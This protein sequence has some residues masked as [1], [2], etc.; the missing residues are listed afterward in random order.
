MIGELILSFFSAPIGSD[1]SCDDS[2]PPNQE[3]T[4]LREC[5]PNF[6]ARTTS[7]RIL[8]MGCGEGYQCIALSELGAKE[9]IGVDPNPRCYEAACQLLECRSNHKVSFCRE[10]PQGLFDIIL[11]KDAMEHYPDP[12]GILD[13]MKSMLAPGGEIL[14]IFGPP[15]FAPY[16]AHVMCF[17]KLPWVNIFFSEKTVMNVRSKYRH[18]GAKRY[19]EM[20][21]GLNRMTIA[22]FE[23]IIKQSDLKVD[24]LYYSCIKRFDFLSKIPI[25]R[26]FFINHVTCILK[27]I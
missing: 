22:R 7:A 21:G 24:Y 18:D 19:E 1:T 16:G 8:D 23:R 26:E 20:E 9:V 12:E 6:D 14:M 25:L 13:E 10:P 5:I 11:S 17:T 3:L 4:Q 27:K 2:Y 15:W